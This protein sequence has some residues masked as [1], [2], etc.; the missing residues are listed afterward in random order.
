[1]SLRCGSGLSNPQSTNTG[2][3]GWKWWY[4]TSFFR[5]IGSLACAIP[6]I[7]D[8][9]EQTLTT[10]TDEEGKI[11]PVPL[12]LA[13]S[14]GIIYSTRYLYKYTDAQAG[15]LGRVI[16]IDEHEE[17][18]RIFNQ[19]AQAQQPYYNNQYTYNQP[20]FD[21]FNGYS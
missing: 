19:R 15:C 16:E 3:F 1:M 7:G 20:S 13:R 6:S 14:D 10:K 18:Q 2:I 5:S 9:L 11:N 8:F 21:A 12:F 17:Q 4:K